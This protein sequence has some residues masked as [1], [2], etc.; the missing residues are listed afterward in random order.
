MP[1]ACF[2]EM[3][4][5]CGSMRNMRQSHIRIKLTC[6]RIAVDA[7]AGRHRRDQSARVRPFQVRHPGAFRRP[8]VPAPVHDVRPVQLHCPKGDQ[9]RRIMTL[10]YCVLYKYTTCLTALCP[11]LPR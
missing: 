10:D 3:C 7:E 6:L 9:L 2:V 1:Y 4:E 8:C 5:K 11:G